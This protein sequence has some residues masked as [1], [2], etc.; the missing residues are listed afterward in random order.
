MSKYHS[1][2][3]VL[4]IA[5]EDHNKLHGELQWEKWF[6]SIIKMFNNK[7][8]DSLLKGLSKKNNTQ[9]S[10]CLD[11]YE[12]VVVKKDGKEGKEDDYNRWI[13]RR[14]DGNKRVELE[15]EI[16]KRKDELEKEIQKR[17]DD[18]SYCDEMQPKW[19]TQLQEIINSR[20]N[21]SFEIRHGNGFAFI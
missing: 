8:P 6:K 15:K 19:D 14:N 3:F 9:L 12:N 7:I 1:I 2:K 16:K 4:D 21:V 5:Y 20:N 17:K 13:K 11:L 18:E 10:R